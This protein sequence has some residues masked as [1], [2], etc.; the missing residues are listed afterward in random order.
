MLHDLYRI[1]D[2]QELVLEEDVEL[3]LAIE[4]FVVDH[5]ALF[6]QQSLQYPEYALARGGSSHTSS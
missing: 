2:L 4:A 5:G 6:G 1:K 3:E